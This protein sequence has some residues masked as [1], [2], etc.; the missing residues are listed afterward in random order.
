MSRLL[1]IVFSMLASG[2]L[3]GQLPAK[4]IVRK[5]EEKV[6]GTTATAS[7]TI[8]IVRPS[9]QR[10]MEMRSW[11][12]GNQYAMIYVDGPARDKGTVFLKRKKEVWNWL[13][14]IERTV[15]LPPSMMSQS[16]MGTDFTNDDLV[17]EFSIVEDYDQVLTGEEKIG[18]RLCYVIRMTPL[19]QA[20]V[21][22]GSIRL[23]I[24]KQEFMQLKGE[25]YDETGTLVNRMTASEIKILGGKLLPSVIEMIPVDKPGNKTIMLYKQ[26]AFDMPLDDSFFSTDNMKKLK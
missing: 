19:P 25:F 11:S 24:D 23:W 14:T 6:R 9:W 26:I 13:P 2:S 22:W 20:A 5:A 10:E 16:W 8:R 4:E 21:V 12:K 7:F 3:A 17:K 18:D 15:K 1:F